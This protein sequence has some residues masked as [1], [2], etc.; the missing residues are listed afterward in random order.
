MF[1]HLR[2]CQS[3]V[4]QRLAQNYHA[5]SLLRDRMEFVLT[6]TLHEVKQ[7]ERS[8]VPSFPPRDSVYANK[9]VSFR[10]VIAAAA[11]VR[12]TRVRPLVLF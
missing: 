5:N 8:I 3:G 2:A 12:S 11:S 1:T 7:L 6:F 10:W 4:F 9:G